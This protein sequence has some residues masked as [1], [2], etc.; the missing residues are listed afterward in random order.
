MLDVYTIED[1]GQVY[2]RS[3]EWLQDGEAIKPTEGELEK[4]EHTGEYNFYNVILGEKY[5]HWIEFKATLWKGELKELNL[6]EYKKED[7]TDRLKY[8]QKMHDEVHKTKSRGKLYKVYRLLVT[9][10]FGA[11]RYAVGT[12]VNITWKLERWLS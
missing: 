10:F 3:T 11:I 8:Q 1:D 2:L 7:N 12:V 6:A 5:D 9:K 4:F